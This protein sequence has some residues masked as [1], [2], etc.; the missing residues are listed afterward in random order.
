MLFVNYH[1]S[2]FMDIRTHFTHSICNSCVPCDKNSS[3]TP[4]FLFVSL[5]SNLYFVCF[6]WWQLDVMKANVSPF[7]LIQP[8]NSFWSI[9]WQI[10]CYYFR[11][12]VK[13]IMCCLLI[14]N[15]TKHAVTSRC[16]RSHVFLISEKN[17]I[18]SKW[19]ENIVILNA[20]SL[21]LL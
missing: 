6:M 15:Y 12:T 2:N 5:E 18:C 19:W 17:K 11:R 14:C 20:M 16:C 7:Q 3:H 8:S 13:F 10:L 1:S 21:Q 9:G 4:S